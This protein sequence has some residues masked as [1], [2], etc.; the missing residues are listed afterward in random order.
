MSNYGPTKTTPSPCHWQHPQFQNITTGK[1]NKKK[2]GSHALI[3]ISLGLPT[4]PVIP[5]KEKK[6]EETST[7]S[8]ARLIIPECG[9]TT[10][11]PQKNHQ[12]PIIN[13]QP[14]PHLP[15]IHHR[16]GSPKKI[17]PT[18]K[19]PIRQTS[20]YPRTPYHKYQE[21][22]PNEGFYIQQ[23][24]PSSGSSISS[25]DLPL[26]SDDDNQPT[27]K[28]ALWGD[29]PKHRGKVDKITP[30]PPLT[31]LSLSSQHKYSFP[32]KEIKLI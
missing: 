1:H 25:L 11:N 14:N 17:S 2:K 16:Q 31:F 8:R 12:L 10:T 20:P 21:P 22:T 5:I 3:W 27:P 29:Q 32:R 19:N 13:T 4:S 26:P 18:P 7:L 24:F 9:D 6:G 28:P 30:S 15:G 23:P